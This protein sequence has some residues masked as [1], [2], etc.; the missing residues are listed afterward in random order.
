MVPYALVAFG[1]AVAVGTILLARKTKTFVP[2]EPPVDPSDPWTAFTPRSPED[3]ER[4]AR[5]RLWPVAG[6]LGGVVLALTGLVAAQTGAF[7]P[8]SPTP[9]PFS[10]EIAGAASPEPSASP[11][12]TPVISPEISPSPS[13]GP[14][15]AVKSTA[16][17]AAKPRVTATPRPP[18]P[19]PTPTPPP[20]PG[21][22]V[23]ASTSCF[24]QTA[25][26]SYQATARTGTKLS[27][28]SVSLDGASMGS[29]AVSG[30]PQ[31]SGNK[32]KVG[33]SKGPHTWTVVATGTD[34]G[35]T[36]KSY[37]LTCP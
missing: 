11:E 29:D 18:T 21:P 2:E 24:N 25:S 20:K 6:V 37:A 16:K 8:G 3:I 33:V 10:V 36:T 9:T 34:G 4:E 31:F 17:P 22:G 30:K 12:E 14:S 5:V 27:S 13:P 23:S 28:L 1:A 7:S 19:K 32:S 15:A 35:R 26:I